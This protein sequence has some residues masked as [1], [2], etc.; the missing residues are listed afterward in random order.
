VSYCNKSY[1]LVVDDVL[2]N[3]LLLQ[4]LLELEG[5]I[6]DTALSG[7][8]ALSKIQAAPPNLI[9]LDI[10]MPG[11]DGWEVIQ[12]IRQNHN[13]PFIPILVVTGCDETSIAQGIEESSAN[14]F[15]RKPINIDKLLKKV[16][17]I[18]EK[19]R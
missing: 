13:L 14:G 17:A 12:Q 15:I 18:L 9:L 8:A 6:V 10:V 19:E 11:M 3:V 16:S 5:Y 2:N 1:I 7:Q 4:T